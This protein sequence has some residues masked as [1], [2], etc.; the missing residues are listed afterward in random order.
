MSYCRFGEA[1]VYIYESVRGFIDCC[2]CSLQE[3]A[4]FKT[5]SEAIAHLQEHEKQGHYTSDVIEV[6]AEEIKTEG[7]E[8]EVYK[9]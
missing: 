2:G 3:V 7:D 9:K 5:R 4:H 8:I 1:D 6:L